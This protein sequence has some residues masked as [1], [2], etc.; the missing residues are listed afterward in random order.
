MSQR[1][2]RNLTPTSKRACGENCW[3]PAPP[4]ANHTTA[5]F[6]L[7]TLNS[8]LIDIHSHVLFGLDDGAK[9]IE[10]SVAMVRMA[11]RSIASTPMSSKNVA[12]KWKK[13]L[14]ECCDSTQDVI[15]I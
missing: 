6:R 13:P 2:E 5:A 4:F 7:S 10:D 11:A 8:D 12:T 9:T 3:P 1:R 14:G 15:F